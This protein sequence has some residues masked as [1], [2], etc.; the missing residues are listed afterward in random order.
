MTTLFSVDGTQD[1]LFYCKFRPYLFQ[2]CT[3]S[4]LIC[5]SLAT[6]DQYCATCTRLRWQQWCNI[7]LAKRLVILN[8]LFWALQGIPYLVLF[9]HIQS[10][11]TN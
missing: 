1:S 8:I 6:F 5:F 7:K 4:S 3:A 10:S 2:L 9:E 11:T